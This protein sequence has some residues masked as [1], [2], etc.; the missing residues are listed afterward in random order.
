[1]NAGISAAGLDAVA[2]RWTV[3]DSTGRH[4]PHFVGSSKIEVGRKILASRFDVFRLEVSASYREAFERALFKV[5]AQKGWQI[6]RA[7]PARS[8]RRAG[9]RAR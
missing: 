3:K 9:A 5:L 8:G 7:V 2:T 4:L 1:M 6:V